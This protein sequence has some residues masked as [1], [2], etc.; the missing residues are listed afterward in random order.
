MTPQRLAIV[1]AQFELTDA[2]PREIRLL[3]HEYGLVPV[4]RYVREGLA[5]DEI[6]WELE[7]DRLG[8]AMKSSGGL[9]SLLMRQ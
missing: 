6:E 2:L 1:R 7:T 8:K 5:P 3:I 9:P 4:M